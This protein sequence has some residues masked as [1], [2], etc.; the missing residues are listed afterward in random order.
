MLELLLKNV[1]LFS[2]EA[3][4]VPLLIIGYIWV[5]RRVFY[6]AT[7]LIMLSILLNAALKITFQMPLIKGLKGFA[8]PSGHMQQSAVLYGWLASSYRSKILR[9][10]IACLLS[11]I[12][13]GLIYFGYHTLYDVL[14][15]LFVA[16]II[17]AFY[18]TM[19]HK[20]PNLLQ[21][22]TIV[23][24]CLLLIY[25]FAYYREIPAHI[26]TTFVILISFIATQHIFGNNKVTPGVGR[27]I[28]STIIAFTIILATKLLFSTELFIELPFILK[29]IEWIMIGMVIPLSVRFVSF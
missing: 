13:T 1:Q 22:F 17:I 27:K 20:T 14:G 26:M 7:C 15:G 19:I 3:L 6:H 25:I 23:V 5:D 16:I 11:L 8:F 24:A 18:K 2:K 4:I 10:V 28:I 9:I 12:A 29:Q 21:L